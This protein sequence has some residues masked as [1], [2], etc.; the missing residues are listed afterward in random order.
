MPQN[1]RSRPDT[2]RSAGKRCFV[3]GFSLLELLLV[4]TLVPI[5]ALTAYSNLSSG[6]KLWK[7]L[8]Q[9]IP[10]EDLQI[11][12][13]KVSRDFLSS[14]IF[15][16][17]PFQG[18]SE[19]VAFA[20]NVQARPEM[21]GDRTLGQVTYRYD[22][23]AQAVMREEKDYSEFFNDKPARVRLALVQ[24]SACTLSYLV[25]DKEQKKYVWAGVWVGEA[26]R[27]PMAVRFSY[28]LTRENR[29]RS[30]VGTFYVPVGGEPQ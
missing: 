10:E 21:G 3:A 12:H 22:A 25:Y 15:S 29:T 19:T 9:P 20:S 14:A 7:A 6:I 23:A 13:N 24:V 18:D 28:T 17:I 26:N 1:S 8:N 16:P 11:F 4:L 30:A 2:G 5:V 27:T